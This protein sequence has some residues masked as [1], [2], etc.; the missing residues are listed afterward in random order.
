MHVLV[1]AATSADGKLASRTREQLAISGPADFARVD[2]VR[3]ASDAVMVGVGTVLADDP[4]LTV[5]DDS[6]VAEREER[7][8]PSQPTRVV[9]DSLAR[10]PPDA[11]VLDASAPTVV[12]ASD[13]APAARVDAIEA[14][15]ATV[16][17][18][19]AERVALP[20]ALAELE[21]RGIADLMVEGGGELIFS[22]FD[23]GLV[24]ELSLYV[25]SLVVGGR[26][27]PTLADG[28]GFTE[29]FP[30]LSLGGVERIDDGVLLS[31]DVE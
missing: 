15:G 1:N 30:S 12:L 27:A 13:A 16:L 19:G 18:A 2:R 25:G 31:Y 21:S 4:S 23:D 22:L 28:D 8:E 10:T 29:S 9:A 11:R 17:R 7:G 24:D 5:D 26:D 14:A 20:A 6:L 3:A